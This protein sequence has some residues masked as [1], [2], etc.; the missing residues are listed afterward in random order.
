MASTHFLAATAMPT[1]APLM[2]K[3][4]HGVGDGAFL[5]TEDTLTIMAGIEAAHGAD[6]LVKAHLV[7]HQVHLATKVIH[8]HHHQPRSVP[9]ERRMARK[10]ARKTAKNHQATK[11]MVVDLATVEDV[12]LILDHGADA[13]DVVDATLKVTGTVVDDG[14]HQDHGTWEL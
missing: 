8:H 5:H 1:P 2:R 7:A 12:V 6:P 4:V 3:V 13:V 11:N 14:V 9:T 10:M